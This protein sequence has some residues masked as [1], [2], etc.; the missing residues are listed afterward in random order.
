MSVRSFQQIV[1]AAQALRAL[2]TSD[3]YPIP[4]D[5]RK[6]FEAIYTG[7]MLDDDKGVIQGPGFTIGKLYH[8]TEDGYGP[9]GGCYWYNLKDDDDVERS[10]P[11]D[12]F[13]IV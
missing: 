6:T 4:K 7:E 11:G 9:L 8:I 1:D 12:E 13:H 2:S 10:R 5:K 3:E